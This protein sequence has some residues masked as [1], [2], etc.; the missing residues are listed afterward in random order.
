MKAHIKIKSLV[1][2]LPRH[3]YYIILHYQRQS[4]GQERAKDCTALVKLNAFDKNTY[5]N[6]EIIESIDNK[7]RRAHGVTQARRL[8]A[9]VFPMA[10]SRPHT[11]GQ[12]TATARAY[13]GAPNDCIIPPSPYPTERAFY[14]VCI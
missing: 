2:R 4:M 13:G 14:H 10:A 3:Y 12:R 8:L 5:N 6:H 9:R 11:G 1:R 7:R